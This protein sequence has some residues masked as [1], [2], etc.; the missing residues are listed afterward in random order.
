MNINIGIGELV[1][2]R[3]PHTLET[4]GLGS[5]IGLTLYDET[6]KIGAL[7]HI[8]LPYLSEFDSIKEILTQNIKFRYADYA[9]PYILN[10]M[11]LMG[12]DV[13]NV[14]AKIIGGASMF[15]RKSSTL[16]IGEKNINAVKNILDCS[17]IKIIA[18]EVGGETGRTVF[19]DLNY[20]T[21][22]VRIYGRDKRDKVI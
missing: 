18:E 3:A 7:A 12:S 5:C 1:V 22:L 11:T 15:R 13:T 21:V 9:I 8:M 14:K 19:F 10:K 20:G 16:N 17:G 4:R 2:D 6:K